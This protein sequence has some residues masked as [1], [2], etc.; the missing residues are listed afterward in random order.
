MA[1]CKIGLRLR[2]LAVDGFWQRG[3]EFLMTPFEDWPI[4]TTFK[5]EQLEGDLLPKELVKRVLFSA[6]KDCYLYKLL[7]SV[8]SMTKFRQHSELER[9]HRILAVLQRWRS[10]STLKNADKQ[11]LTIEEVASAKMFWV[12]WI[13]KEIAS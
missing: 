13:Q 7:H 11:T 9:L 6:S 1:Y 2:E 3:P 5:M 8:G 4:K 12:K 10:V